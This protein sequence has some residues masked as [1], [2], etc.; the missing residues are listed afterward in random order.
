M[1]AIK[2]SFIVELPLYDVLTQLSAPHD[3]PDWTSRGRAGGLRVEVLA[4]GTRV[5][6]TGD[7]ADV[8]PRVLAPVV[9]GFT[10]QMLRSRH[11]SS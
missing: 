10:S 6:L 2:Y 8:A 5:T 11:S 1:S 3:A 9:R 4:R 7:S